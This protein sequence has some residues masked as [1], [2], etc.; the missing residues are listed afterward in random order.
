MAYNPSP[1]VAV[2]R[3]A[4]NKLNATTGAVI[5]YVNVDG[6]YG[7]TSYGHTKDKCSEMGRLGDHLFEET[8]KFYNI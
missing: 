4:A 8:H 2:A 1:K 3:D 6:S 7:M 5:I